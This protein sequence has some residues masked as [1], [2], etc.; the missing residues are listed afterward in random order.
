VVESEDTPKG[1]HPKDGDDEKK[2]DDGDEEE[3]DGP[4]EKYV[5]DEKPIT[6][7]PKLDI[8]EEIHEVYEK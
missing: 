5:K 1:D 2:S 8:Y 7:N 3:E 4:V 6:E